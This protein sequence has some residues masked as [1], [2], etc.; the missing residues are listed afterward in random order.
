MPVEA[1][2]DRVAEAERFSV[3]AWAFRPAKK[4]QQIDGF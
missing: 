2:A 1:S 3:E 4:V